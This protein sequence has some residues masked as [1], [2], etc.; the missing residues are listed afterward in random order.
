[1]KYPKAIKHNSDQIISVIE[2][3]IQII[4]DELESEEMV[5]ESTLNDSF[6]AKDFLVKYKLN[7]IGT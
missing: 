1:L 7:D 6:I 5:S 3:K 2:E 4:R